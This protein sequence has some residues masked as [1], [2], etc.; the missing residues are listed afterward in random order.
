MPH[1]A[2]G[3]LPKTEVVK[4]TITLP[5]ALKADLDHYAALHAET[6]GEAV[7]ATTLIPH[8]AAS[9]I[10]RDRTFQRARKRVSK[11]G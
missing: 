7:D 5:I 4:V 10:A 6:H 11:A 9:F 3:P 1:A 8:I 2:Y